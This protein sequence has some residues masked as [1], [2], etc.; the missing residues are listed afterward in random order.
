MENERSLT[1]K[2]VVS[3]LFQNEPTPKD[4]LGELYHLHRQALQ[5]SEYEKLQ[6]SAADAARHLQKLSALFSIRFHI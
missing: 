1:G 3:K 4:D 5:T 6:I 2:D